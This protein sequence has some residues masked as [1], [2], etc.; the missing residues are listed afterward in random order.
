MRREYTGK[1]PMTTEQ[2]LSAKYYTMRYL[3]WLRDYNGLKDS[4]SAIGYEGA[5]MPHAKNKLSNPTENLAIKRAEIRAK[6]DKVEKCAMR[7]AG[8]DL[9]EWILKG[10]TEDLTFNDLSQQG[11]PLERTAY[12]EKRRKYYYL[13]SKE[14]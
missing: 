3:E 2:Y 5:D 12:Y 6:M 14:I 13:L 8:P 10:V 11:M 7:A 1:Y 4:V 9:F